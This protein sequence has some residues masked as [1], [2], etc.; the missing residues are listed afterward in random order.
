VLPASNNYGHPM[1]LLD[2]AAARLAIIAPDLPPVREVIRHGETGLLFRP[3]DVTDLAAGIHR[4]A[5]EPQL[6]AR[7]AAAAWLQV[8]ETGS[9]RLRARALVESPIARDAR[10]WPSPESLSHF[11]KAS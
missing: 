2:Y 11:V 5:G 3:G 1:K 10:P 9:W 7:L 8:T 6:R 4:L